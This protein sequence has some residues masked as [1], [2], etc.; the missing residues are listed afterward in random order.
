MLFLNVLISSAVGAGT[1]CCAERLGALALAREFGLEGILAFE[2]PNDNNNTA[3][4]IVL[5]SRNQPRSLLRSASR[6]CSS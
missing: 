4:T 3:N 5:V 2:Q 6:K 1:V